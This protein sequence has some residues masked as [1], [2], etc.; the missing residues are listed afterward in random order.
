VGFRA[1]PRWGSGAKLPEAR[2]A[3]TICNVK[4]FF[5]RCVRR[6]Y[7]VYLQAHAESST[8]TL[9]LQKTL[10]ICA[11]LTTHPGRG[12][13]GSGHRMCPPVATPEREKTCLKTVAVQIGD[14]RKRLTLSLFAVLLHTMYSELE[15][16]YRGSR[17]IVLAINS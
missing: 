5:S 3:Y 12:R 15:N 16:N 8:P 4:K 7:T 9:L 14:F 13:V 17:Q 6:R 1:E 10:R 2:Y 11:N